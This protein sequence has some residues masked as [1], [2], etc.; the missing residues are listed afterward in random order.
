MQQGSSFQGFYSQRP[1]VNTAIDAM[2]AGTIVG[3]TLGG[4]FTERTFFYPSISCVRGGDFTGVLRSPNEIMLS[5]PT[6]QRQSG[7]GTCNPCQ[8]YTVIATR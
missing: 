6:V 1:G 5:I 8:H 4:T 7:D 2:F 3:T